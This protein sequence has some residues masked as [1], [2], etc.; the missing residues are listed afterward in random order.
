MKYAVDMTSG[1]MIIFWGGSSHI[2]KV[3]ILQKKI[4]RII[5]NTRKSDSCRQVFSKME[6][7]MVYSQYIYS[8]ILFTFNNRYLFNT[9]ND[10]HKYIYFFFI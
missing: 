6:I 5:T 8:L 4:V 7:M 9:N 2:H 1:I 3:F 10:I